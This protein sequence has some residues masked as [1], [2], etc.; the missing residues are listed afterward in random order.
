MVHSG[1]TLALLNQDSV[2]SCQFIFDI[3]S[4]CIHCI[5]TNDISDG[6]DLKAFSKTVSAQ[7]Q[8]PD[9]KPKL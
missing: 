2:E 4:R 6:K 9:R 5:V 1:Q 7:A 8:I 3:L